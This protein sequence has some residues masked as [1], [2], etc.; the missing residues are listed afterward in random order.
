MVAARLDESGLRLDLPD[1]ARI[2]PTFT[3]STSL[4][5]K[6]SSTAEV[7]TRLPQRSFAFDVPP[8]SVYAIVGVPSR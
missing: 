7:L 1:L 6:S 2:D 3:G 5:F 8:K 4:H